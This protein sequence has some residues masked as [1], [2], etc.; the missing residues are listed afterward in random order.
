[1]NVFWLYVQNN[2]TKILGLIVGTLTVLVGTD[3]IPPEHVKYYMA[4]I[5]IATYWRG[6]SNSNSTVT[7]QAATTIIA[8]HAALTDT[9]TDADKAKL[10]KDIPK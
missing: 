8:Q 7:T 2:G 4:A 5:A 3:I 9:L 6:Q 10:T 1:M